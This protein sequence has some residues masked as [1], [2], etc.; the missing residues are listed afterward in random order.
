M[1]SRWLRTSES[2]QV[3]NRW[4]EGPDGPIETWLCAPPRAGGTALPLVVDIHGG[5]VGG[6]APAPS[7]EVRMLTSAGYRVALPNIAGS[8]GYGG[9]WITRHLGRWGEADAA[10]L[11]AV[12][13][14]LE[15]EGLVQDGRV[16][17]L[18]L[19][20]G[21]YLVHWLLG[22]EPE[23]FR[24][25]V[26]EAGVANQL[27]DWANSDCGPDY[28]R[29]YR[30]GEPFDEAGVEALWRQSPLRLAPRIRAPLLMFQGEADLRCP[31]ADN[32]QLFLLLRSLGRTVEYVL[33]PDSWH[34]F[35]VAGR[36][37]R[38]ID[39]HERMLDWFQRHL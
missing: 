5:P 4:I 19:S 7:L 34:A 15:Q 3:E 24:A 9:A 32:E 28:D 27:N 36:P 38:R 10:D 1:G 39:R 33:Y 6:W 26:S 14:R 8:A 22:A 20:Y 31:P 17:L 35:G 25:G 2:P 30:L 16:G 18:G 13:D 29:R 12:V 37:D 23:R 11:L 21:G